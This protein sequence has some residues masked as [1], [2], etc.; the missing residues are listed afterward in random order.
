MSENAIHIHEDHWAMRTLHP[1]AAEAE[2]RAE[3]AAA[4]LAAERNRS[5]SGFG[6][7]DIH[8]I[9]PPSISYRDI[10]LALA[11]AAAA[12]APVM[13]RVRRFSATIGMAID[14]GEHD[15]F[16][17]YEEDAWCYG[18]G[19]HCFLKLE[20]KGE[21]VDQ[22]WFDLASRDPED[23][24]ALGAAI[25]AVD[26]L[27]PSILVDHWMSLAGRIGDAGFLDG[28]FSTYRERVEIATRATEDMIAR[29]EREPPKPPAVPRKR[30]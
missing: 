1:L 24:A 18:L 17:S 6:W 20:P 9:K 11:E 5:P 30:G 27:A 13:P 19:D 23:M 25:R 21:L 14:T 3:L 8:I 29:L 16:G 4:E 12:L 26:A 2:A 15:P 10:G 28:Y 22:I 7:T